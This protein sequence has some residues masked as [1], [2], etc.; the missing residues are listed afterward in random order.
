MQIVIEIPDSF[1]ETVKNSNGMS[2]TQG[3]VIVDAF[4]NGKILPKYHGRLISADALKQLILSVF[5]MV[6]S[7]L[8]NEIDK[9]ETIIPATN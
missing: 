2:I 5:P 9:I 8:A 4:Y 6:Y 7:G 1:Y 3:N